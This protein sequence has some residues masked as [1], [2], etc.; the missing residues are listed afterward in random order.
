[1]QQAER[2]EK[3]ARLASALED[4]L[5]RGLTDRAKM[6]HC[7]VDHDRPGYLRIGVLYDPSNATRLLDVGPSSGDSSK[8]ESFR[9]LWGEKAELRRFK[10]GS[11]SES[12]VWEVSR[13]EEAA[14]IPGRIVRWLLKRNFGLDED[15]I[16]GLSSDQA[17]LDVI[18]VPA[19]ARDAI[20]AQGAEKL[21]FRPM[22]DAY[23]DLVK[24]LKGIDSELPLAILQVQPASDLLRYS[25]TFVPHPLDTAR[26]TSAPDSVK[27]IPRAE[28]I[29]QFESSPRWPDDL[30]AIQKVK[31]ALLEKLARIITTQRR[32]ST[33]RIVFESGR[34]DVEDSAGLEIFL[35]AGIAFL[36]RIYH[37]RERTLLERVINDEIPTAGT[38]LPLPPKRLALPAMALHLPRF[39]HLPQHH[40]AIAPLHHRYPSLSTA[41]RLLKRWFAAHMLSQISTEAIEL[42]MV[43]IYLDPGSLQRPASAPAAFTRAMTLL[44]NWDWRSDP[45]VLPPFSTVES[46]RPRMPVETRTQI[47]AAFEELRRKDKDIHHGAWVIATEQDVDGL[48]WTKQV[49][50]LV[51][52]RVRKLARATLDTLTAG[53]L[54][55]MMD[56][57]VF[58]SLW[59]MSFS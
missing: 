14:L 1:M 48:R 35:P 22:M 52:S 19:L 32:G 30:G 47:V 9:E 56:V 11:I 24:L 2:P 45:L 5:R 28:I 7:V 33:A 44:A 25:S 46:G 53:S 55:G 17:W 50:K 23:E 31:L 15:R 6:I 40:S 41:T 4:L 16:V 21:G 49:N 57:K 51:A 38:S 43:S 26:F 20:A 42:L 29:L 59:T 58:P 34:S 36:I 8:G 13:P 27:W 37:E 3:M 10:D 39:L 18:Q 54:N 12:V